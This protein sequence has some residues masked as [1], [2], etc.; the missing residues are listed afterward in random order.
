MDG[1]SREPGRELRATFELCEMLIGADVCFLHDVLT[2][3]VVAQDTAYRAIDPLVVAAHEG[4]NKARSPSRTRCTIS[5]S[6][7]PSTLA[8]SKMGK[9]IAPPYTSHSIHWSR[10]S[11]WMVTA[12]DPG[13]GYAGHGGR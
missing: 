11:F 13:P 10:Q 3:G 8:F 9:L 2:L 5:A 6:V 1:N 4:S 7:Q 12:D